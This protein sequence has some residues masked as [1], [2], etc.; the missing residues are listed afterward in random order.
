MEI[1]GSWVYRNT[2]LS[3]ET[4]VTQFKSSLRNGWG[5]VSGSSTCGGDLRFAVSVCMPRE[6]VHALSPHDC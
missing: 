5:I 4:I 2:T 3:T 6:Y 1:G